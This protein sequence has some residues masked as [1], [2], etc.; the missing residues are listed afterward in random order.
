MTNKSILGAVIL[1]TPLLPCRGAEPLYAGKPLAFWL[2]ELKS[3]D[4]LIREE[5]LA[6]LSEAGTAARAAAPAILKLTHHSDAPL[7][8]ASLAALKFVADPK[9]AR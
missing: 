8:A 4:P 6:V 2:D 9:D 1:L 7:R 3:D 5:A